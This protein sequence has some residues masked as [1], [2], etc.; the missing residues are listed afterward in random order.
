MWK[1]VS[2]DYIITTIE[3]GSDG[4]SGDGGAATSAQ[5]D[6]PHGGLDSS[7]NAYMADSYN[8]R[9]RM[10][11]AIS[12]NIS[13]IAGTGVAGYSGDGGA[14]TSAELKILEEWPW[15]HLGMYTQQVNFN[16]RIRMIDAISGNISTIAGTGVAGHSGDGGAATS[17][18]CIVLTEW[19]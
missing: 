12:V 4:Y 2:G 5:L 13:T 14:A 6:N 10:I 7:G 19:P 8:N 9:I 18:R 11:D 1:D 3:A 15:T 16:N 17:A